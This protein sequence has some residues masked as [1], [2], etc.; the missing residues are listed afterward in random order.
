M[1][2]GDIGELGSSA[3]QQHYMLGRDLVSVKGLN[4]VVAVG[5]FATCG[6][7]GY[8]RS[9]NMAKKCRL[10]NSRAGFAV[11]TQFN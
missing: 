7:E 11:L 1:V 2:M 4:F 3:A 5:E 9:T 8:A 10:F 6:Q